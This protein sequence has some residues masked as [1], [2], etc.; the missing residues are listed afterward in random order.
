MK[1]HVRFI[2]KSN[3]EVTLTRGYTNDDE[4]FEIMDNVNPDLWIISFEQ[5]T[6]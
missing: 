1:K 2:C 4:F 6:F 5:V 3:P